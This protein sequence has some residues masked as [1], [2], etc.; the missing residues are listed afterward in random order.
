MRLKKKVFFL[1]IPKTGGEFINN[2]LRKLVPDDQY[3]EH[4][5]NYVHLEDNSFLDKR[6]LSGHI[7]LKRFQKIA[8]DLEDRLIFTI[9]REPYNHLISHISWVRNLT[10]NSKRF[11]AHPKIVQD[12]AI[13]LEQINFENAPEVE[14]FVN[15]I[16]GYALAAF[17]NR[18]IRYFVDPS[19]AEWTTS[20]HKCQA[21][22]MAKQI[23]YVGLF[24]EFENS[25]NQILEILD[26]DENISL[27]MKPINSENKKAIQD[28]HA[29]PEIKSILYPL[30]CNDLELYKA[31]LHANI[32]NS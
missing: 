20:T 5:Q 28:I 11:N 1:H 21:I 12:L 32:S 16:D 10:Q 27:D 4:L 6:F 24:E 8:D 2:L 13:K 23:T 31:F 30:V 19:D 29:K 22:E 14:E 17:E 9:I 18:Q 25:V 7:P 3:L 15:Q 26:Q